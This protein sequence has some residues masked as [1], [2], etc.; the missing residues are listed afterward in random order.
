VP[1]GHRQETF[2]QLLKEGDHPMSNVDRP[3]ARLVDATDETLAECGRTAW[4]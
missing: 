2:N 3:A 4:R 1:I